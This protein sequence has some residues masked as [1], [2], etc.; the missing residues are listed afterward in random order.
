MSS[1][2]LVAAGSRLAVGSSRNRISGSRASARASARRCCS[3]PERRRAGRTAR[4][5]RPTLREQISGRRADCRSGYPGRR[6]GE[7][8][9]GGRRPA[10]HD[11]ALEYHRAPIPVRMGAPAPCNRSRCWAAKPHSNPD[12]SCLTRS[13]RPDQHGRSPGFKAERDTV[14]D[15]ELADAEAGVLQND[16]QITYGRAHEIIPRGFRRRAARSMPLH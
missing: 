6:K 1:T 12:Q 13:I 11:R 3:P 2:A 7:R 15:R 5:L 16:R 14:E 8:D 10:Q 9:V 4:F